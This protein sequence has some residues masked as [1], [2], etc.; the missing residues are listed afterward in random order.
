MNPPI[1]KSELE[2]VRIVWELG[3]ATVRDVANALPSDRDVD[4]WTVQT[5][6]R[7]L[8]EKGYISVRKVGRS[9]VYSTQIKPKHVIGQMVDNF[10]SQ[11]FDGE[12]VP[13]LQHLIRERGLSD[14]EVDELQQTLDE[15]TDK[16]NQ[17]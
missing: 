9:N 3:E 7:R 6:L 16:R 14:E 17:S 2:I 10:L 15:F 13:L 11:M 8:A 1:P 4:F 12:A 5:Y